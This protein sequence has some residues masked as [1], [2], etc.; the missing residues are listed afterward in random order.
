RKARGLP[1]PSWK[2]LVIGILILL[3][4]P[5]VISNFILGNLEVEGTR[6]HYIRMQNIG[7]RKF[8]RSIKIDK[9]NT[10]TNQMLPKF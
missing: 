7:G 10:F 3:A 4:N 9:M 8:R 1:N 2:I 5:R 6:G